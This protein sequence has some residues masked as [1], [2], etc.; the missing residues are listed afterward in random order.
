M[1]GS[2]MDLKKAFDSICAVSGSVG[3]VMIREDGS[4]AR[5]SG[6]LCES[7]EAYALASMMKD[8]A[9]LVSMVEPEVKSLTRMTVSRQSDLRVVATPHQGHV[10]GVKLAKR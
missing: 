4:I 7:S 8:A 9:Q 10:F 1:S 2:S 5:A 3:A 6:D